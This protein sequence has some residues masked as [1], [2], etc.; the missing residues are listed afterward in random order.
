MDPRLA[1]PAFA[2]GPAPDPSLA[3]RHRSERGAQGQRPS[4]SRMGRR[5]LER[6]G[7]R[8]TRP[9]GRRPRPSRPPASPAEPEPR[10]AGPDRAALPRGPRLER[11]RS[12]SGHVGVRRPQPARTHPR[13][14]PPRPRYPTGDGQMTDQT[15][16]DRRL[17]DLLG[18]IAD[19]VDTDVDAMAVTR[20]AATR[21]L[22]RGTVWA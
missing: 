4:P 11:D 7:D 14:D 2:A 15:S 16:F 20:L 6:G 18:R 13:T 22:T 9:A 19:R 1:A 12:S 5:H 17:T 21:A 10:T 8:R 3:H